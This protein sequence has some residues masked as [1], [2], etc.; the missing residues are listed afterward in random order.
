LYSTRSLKALG[1]LQHHKEGC[2]AIAFARSPR[3]TLSSGDRSEDVQDEDEDE[4]MTPAEKEERA[5]WLIS[6]GKESRV[7]IWALISFEKRG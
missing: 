2:Q 7:C 5:R 3:R 1:T 6:G 4:E